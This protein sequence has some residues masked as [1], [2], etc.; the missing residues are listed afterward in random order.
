[1]SRN[2]WLPALLWL[3]IILVATSIPNP[4]VPSVPGGDK[5]AHAIMYGVLAVL[6]AYALAGGRSARTALVAT[7]PLVAL[8]AAADEWHQRFI[9]GRSAS[10]DDWLADVAGAGVA[11]LVSGAVLGR[12]ETAS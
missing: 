6:V 9:P 8:L 7:L 11:L 2:R 5:A 3:A 4:D 10:M 1:V 12:R